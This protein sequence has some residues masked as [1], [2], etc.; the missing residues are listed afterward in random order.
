MS[1]I[2]WQEPVQNLAEPPKKGDNP[3]R[4][5]LEESRP[6]ASVASA[7]SGSSLPDASGLV[8]SLSAAAKS[9]PVTFMASL[10]A[11]MWPLGYRVMGGYTLLHTS[12]ARGHRR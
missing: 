5:G 11:A 3:C 2:W 6:Y 4:S 8:G 10:Q 7:R 9:F 12:V 1:R